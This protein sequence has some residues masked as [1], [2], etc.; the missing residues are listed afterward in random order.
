MGGSGGGLCGR[1]R[2]VSCEQAIA[3]IIQLALS[4]WPVAHVPGED[5]TCFGD[6]KSSAGACGGARGSKTDHGSAP[7]KGF[8]TFR[9]GQ[10]QRSTRTCGSGFAALFCEPPSSDSDQRS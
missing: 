6:C 8:D 9:N 2:S 7:R 5:Q 10:M 4:A 3:T 1:K